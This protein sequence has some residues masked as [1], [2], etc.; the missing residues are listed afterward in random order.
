MKTI[1][2]VAAVF[3]GFI[4]LSAFVS[5]YTGISKKHPLSGIDE[6]RNVKDFSEIAMSVSG[7]VYVKQGSPCKVVLEGDQNDLEKIETVVEGDKLKIK[8]KSWTSNI[9]K[10]TAYVTCP[11]IEGLYVAGS[12]KM[13]AENDFSSEELDLAV[14]GSGELRLKGIQCEEMDI[15]V[16]GSGDVYVDNDGQAEEVDIS[17]SGSGK[18]YAEN[19]K[20]NECD[21]H[22][23][24]SG[25]CKIYV[26]DELEARI[27]GSGS[28]YY[29]GTP[30]IDASSSGSGKVKSL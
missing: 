13:I 3:V 25:S 19:L 18:V 24:G 26:T 23:S 7:T 14:S 8:T 27:S 6:E 17:I 1:V 5:D 10:I 30:K 15:H 29:K 9:G 22:I 16:S 12:G 2:K 20:V 21:A 4:I 11:N 28:V